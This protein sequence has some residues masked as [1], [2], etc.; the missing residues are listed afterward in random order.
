MASEKALIQRMNRN[1]QEK[2]GRDLSAIELA[3]ELEKVGVKMPVPKTPLELLA[4]KVADALS[5]E[6]RIDKETGF[7]YSANVAY[8]TE[9]GFLWGDLDKVDRRK[10]QNN[11]MFRRNQMVGDAFGIKID[12]DRWNKVNPNEEPIQPELDFT[13]D[14][15][16][17]L[18]APRE[19][20][21][22]AA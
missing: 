22:K 9:Q 17:K 11:Y 7:T 15:E 8:E 21:K 10:M 1:L 3:G 4:K 18:N 14:V 19:T 12:C 2:Y 16:W 13:L 20:K 6:E 5:E